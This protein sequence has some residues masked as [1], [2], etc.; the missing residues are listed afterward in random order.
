MYMKVTLLPAYTSV[1]EF[2][3]IGLSET[4]LSSETSCD[5]DNLEIPGYNIIRAD[6]SSI[7]KRGVVWVYYRNWLSFKDINVKYLL[8][9]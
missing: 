9:W 5:H 6:H 3:I 2:D 8:E 7:D 1:H 4:Y